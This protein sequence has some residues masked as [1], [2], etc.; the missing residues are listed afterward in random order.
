MRP[1][2]SQGVTFRPW[3]YFVHEPI[4]HEPIPKQQTLKS[5]KLKEFA[6]N[7]FKTDENGEGLSVENGEIVRHEHFLL[8][9]Q[10]FP[11]LY[12]RH[13]KQGLVWGKVKSYLA[14]FTLITIP[15]TDFN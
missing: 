14:K 5:S 7:E 10:C 15:P 11:D 6:E 2:C 12:S 9:P 13:V 4:V 3:P 1:A 8:F